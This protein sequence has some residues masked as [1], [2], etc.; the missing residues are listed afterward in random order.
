MGKNWP[1]K[2]LREIFDVTMQT[3]YFPVNLKDLKA[4]INFVSL[5]K[6]ME[7]LDRFKRLPLTNTFILA[8]LTAT[9]WNG[10]IRY[11]QYA[12]TLNIMGELIRILWNWPGD[13]IC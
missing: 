13:R 2:D 5:G 1:V 8:A 9:G 12:L 11:G 7:I 3:E 4:Q 6:D 10:L